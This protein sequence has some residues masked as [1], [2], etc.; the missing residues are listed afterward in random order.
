MIQS[1]ARVIY[2][3]RAILLKICADRA[4]LPIGAWGQA[5]MTSERLC[6]MALIRKPAR[7]RHLRQRQL[8][9]IE[10]AL[11]ALDPL[12]QHE[13]VRAFSDTRRSCCGVNAC[14]GSLIVTAVV[15]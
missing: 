15:V 8:A 3:I 13:L 12:P 7:Q 14:T 6:E 5:D 11:R 9:L 10:Q 2:H 4:I 1:Q